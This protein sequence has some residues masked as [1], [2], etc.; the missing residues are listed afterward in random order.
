MRIQVSRVD[1]DGRRIDFRLVHEG[2][3]VP[4]P[5]RGRRERHVQP[6]QSAEEELAVLKGM[7]RSVK[8]LA[9]RSAKLAAGKVGKAGRVAPA[10]RGKAAGKGGAGKAAKATRPKSMAAKSRR[11]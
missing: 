11:S 4:P 7:D 9:K 10:A 2:E 3:T 1:L 8:A 6:A 5:G